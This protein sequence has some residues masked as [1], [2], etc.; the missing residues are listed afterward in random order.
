MFTFADGGQAARV[1]AVPT[2]ALTVDLAIGV[3]GVPRGR[4]TELYGP[5]SAGKTSLALSTAAQAI[6]AGGMAAIID[7]EHAITPSHCAGMGVDL[8]YLLIYQPESGEDAFTKLEQLV[9]SDLFDVVIVD[10]VAALVPKVELEGEMEDMQVGA[11]A[12]LIAKGLRKVTGAI[13]N[14]KAAVIFINQ[15]RTKIGVMYGNPED[16]PGGKALKFY[17]SVRLEVRSASSERIKDPND[18]KGLIGLHSKVKVVKNKVAPPHRTAEYD[19]IWGKGIDPVTSTID[20]G[21]ASGVLVRQSNN[22]VLITGTGEVLSGPDGKAIYGKENISRFLRENPDRLEE[23][24]QLVRAVI[25]D[26][27][28]LPAETADSPIPDSDFDEDGP[29]AEVRAS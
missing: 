17:A 20:A 22:S 8:E 5:E 24:A 2:G 21:L 11:Q 27:K 23:I 25:E 4:V 28:R 14:S 10:S 3:G 9:K 18:P 19:L 7:A 29:G 6:K 16:T 26:A 15:L 12:R 1:S 13:G